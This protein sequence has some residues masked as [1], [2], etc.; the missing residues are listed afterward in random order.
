MNPSVVCTWNC[1]KYGEVKCSRKAVPYSLNVQE[2]KSTLLG[3]I[4]RD[5]FVLEW[6]STVKISGIQSQKSDSNHYFGVD[7]TMIWKW[8]QCQMKCSLTNMIPNMT[9]NRVDFHSTESKSHG[10]QFSWNCVGRGYP[11]LSCGRYEFYVVVTG[12]TWQIRS[13][14]YVALMG[15]LSQTPV[16]VTAT[17]NLYLPR[18][19]PVTAT[20]YSRYTPF[21]KIVLHVRGSY[22]T[23]LREGVT[24]ELEESRDHLKF[25]ENF[26]IQCSKKTVV[27]LHAQQATNLWT[28]T[29]GASY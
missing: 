12:S 24:A 14:R 25:R 28:C 1:K 20:M 19:A 22:G 18:I 4:I 15:R 2:W 29:A 26:S 3:V 16:H 13:Q 17:Y 6:K 10:R 7:S 11:W 27:L 8:I 9:S 5:H 21:A 23:A